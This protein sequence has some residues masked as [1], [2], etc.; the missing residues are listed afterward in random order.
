MGNK[1]GKRKASSPAESICPAPSRPVTP[2][3]QAPSRYGT[4]DQSGNPDFTRAAQAFNER[5]SSPPS[6]EEISYEEYLTGACNKI[7]EVALNTS[8]IPNPILSLFIDLLGRLTHSEPDILLE[9]LQGNPIIDKLTAEAVSKAKAPA[10]PPPPPPPSME[11]DSPTTPT[12]PKPP[13]TMPPARG[14][15]TPLAP[16]SGA[17]AS[18]TPPTPPAAPAPQGKPAPLWSPLA[19]RAPKHAPPPLPPRWPPSRPTPR[20]SVPRPP[21]PAKPT[22]RQRWWP[23]KPPSAINHTLHSWAGRPFS[24]IPVANLGDSHI[25][26]ASWTVG[27]NIF[28]TA[29]KAPY[30]HGLDKHTYSSI[31]NEALST[32]PAFSDKGVI[33]KAYEPA[34]CLQIKGLPTWDPTTNKP[35]ELTSVFKTLDGLGIFEDVKLIKNGSP[36]PSGA[37]SWVQDPST[38]NAESRPCA[39]TVRFLNNNSRETGALL[40]KAFYLLSHRRH[41]D[42]W[43]PRPPPPKKGLSPQA[44][45]P[46]AGHT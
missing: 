2:D 33:I 1:K 43:P 36:D 21:A 44:A 24:G 46:Q 38:F 42:K 9:L 14:N 13:D 5:H 12:A 15:L 25:L 34:A 18:A 39:V 8:P 35:V 45:R 37:F 40:K 6:Q 26:A 27:C 41:F 4:P 20:P 30:N 23:L 11:V 3:F 29:T 7:E 31:V 32:M 16:Q 22:H 10:P 28:I 17:L 19:K